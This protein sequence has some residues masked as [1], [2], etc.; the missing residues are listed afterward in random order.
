[1]GNGKMGTKRRNRNDHSQHQHAGASVTKPR[2]LEKHIEKQILLWLNMQS[3]I[4]AWKNKSTGTYDPVRKC[5]RRAT[6]RFTQKGTSDIIG[7]VAGKMLCIEVKRP[8]G[9]LTQEQHDFL[10]E[11]TDLGAIC[12]VAYSLDD[13]ILLI[14]GLLTPNALAV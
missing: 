5:F 4:K 6:S 13:V 14:T 10:N 1:M 2:V 9:K 12:M 11:M 7:I 8:G 3:G